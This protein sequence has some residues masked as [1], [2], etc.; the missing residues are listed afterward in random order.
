MGSTADIQEEELQQT[1]LA[2]DWFD[3]ERKAHKGTNLSNAPL[4]RVPLTFKDEQVQDLIVVH[5]ASASSQSPQEYLATFSPLVLEECAAQLVNSN[6]NDLERNPNEPC[7]VAVV[8]SVRGH[9]PLCTSHH[10]V[11]P[12]Q[13]APYRV[14][15]LTLKQGFNS[16]FSKLDIV[17]LSQLPTVHRPHT[18]RQLCAPC[19]HQQTERGQTVHALGIVDGHEGEQSLRV[20]FLLSRGARPEDHARLSRVAECMVVKSRWYLTACANIATVH[21]EWAAVQR[22][23]KLPFLNTVL[24][25]TVHVVVCVY[26]CA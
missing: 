23:G 11:A 14:A 1:V 3:L 15:R 7:V 4:K 21:R 18:T 13:V 25:A 8:E 19:H 16:L 20:R 6:R 5:R 2:W 17:L 10:H 22:V 9:T 26:I 24:H 12:P